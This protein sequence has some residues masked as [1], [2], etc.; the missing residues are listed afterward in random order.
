MYR[1]ID[2]R[3]EVQGVNQEYGAR[4]RRFWV[5]IVACLARRLGGAS[6]ESLYHF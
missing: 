1:L 6:Q 5:Q 4:W 2:K 3:S